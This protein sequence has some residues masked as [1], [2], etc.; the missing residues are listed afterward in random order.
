MK[1]S[2]CMIVK[3]EEAV[4]ARCLDSVKDVFD[5]IIIVDTGSADATKSIASAYTDKI[6]NYTWCNDFSSAR[7]FSF[8]KA[9]GDYIM[10]LDAD[11]VLEEKDRLA[12]VSLKES[13]KPETDVV[14][15]KYVTQSDSSGN[16]VFFYYRE[17]L[18]KRM[19]NL[20][21]HGFVHE[22]ITPSGNIVYEDICV[23]H[24]PLESKKRDPERNLKI[25]KEMLARGA[26][27]SA[28]ETYYYARELYYNGKYSD[29]AIQLERFLENPKGWSADKVGASVML[30]QIYAESAPEKARKFL[31]SALI[32]DSVNPQIL[33]FMGDSFKAEGKINQAIFWY[34]SALICPDEYR[35]NGFVLTE[36][37]RYYPLLQLC[38]CYD[39]SGQHDKAKE[40]NRLA[41]EIKPDSEQV[42][43]NKL[44]FDSLD[45]KDTEKISSEN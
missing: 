29:A 28:R 18:V 12:L 3:N 15:M 2:L 39:I 32:Y 16:P 7:N 5:E 24:K 19:A 25:Y 38:V 36:Y 1:F 10:W 27:F 30:Y 41:G 35:N 26:V 9:T 13:I 11:D 44:Y 8:S 42:L 6:F 23:Y 40:C 17:R 31:A 45:N 4:L 34:N 33:C 20:K 22:V 21:W 37:E 43:H 14:M